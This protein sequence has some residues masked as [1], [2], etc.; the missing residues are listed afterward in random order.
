MRHKFGAC[1]VSHPDSAKIWQDR[2]S[3]YVPTR[4]RIA[5]RMAAGRVCPNLDYSGE[6]GVGEGLYI[7][8]YIRFGVNVRS[9]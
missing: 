6:I 1:L 5:L 4:A 3:P 9:A 8:W 2:T 7:R